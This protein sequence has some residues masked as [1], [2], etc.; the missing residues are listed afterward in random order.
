MKTIKMITALTLMTL[1]LSSCD[2]LSAFGP[3]DTSTGGDELPS[4]A[5]GE[6]FEL[7]FGGA[8]QIPEA[9]LV[10]VRF[11]DVLEDSRCPLDVTCVWAGNAKVAVELR[12]QGK[13]ANRIE[14]NTTSDPREVF[15]GEYRVD[16]VR[17]T[18]P[19]QSTVDLTEQEYSIFL[20]VEGVEEDS[21]F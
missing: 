16:L 19:K 4:V 12:E 6:E 8:V 11:L 10:F 14:L 9:N 1:A 21:G 18:P 3:P 20:K 2:L 13:A 17:V 15:F 7:A 5:M